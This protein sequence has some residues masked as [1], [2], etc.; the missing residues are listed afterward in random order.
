MLPGRDKLETKEN[1]P[2]SVGLGKGWRQPTPSWN[3]RAV[4]NLDS[5]LR[6]KPCSEAPGESN[7]WKVVM[8]I[9]LDLP[10]SC[11]GGKLELRGRTRKSGKFK[12]IREVQ[13]FTRICF[14][15]GNKE[16]T[17]SS[18]RGA[19]SGLDTSHWRQARAGWAGSRAKGL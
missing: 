2:L 15:L 1:A 5:N 19:G 14:S 12:R 11:Q 8:S 18:W 9:I 13:G 6:Q 17:W 10:T 7:H 16:G 4:C 3:L